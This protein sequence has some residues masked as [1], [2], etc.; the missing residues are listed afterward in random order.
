MLATGFRGDAFPVFGKALAARLRETGGSCRRARARMS[1]V[2]VRID[3]RITEF[4]S[5]WRRDV[6]VP[7]PR[8]LRPRGFGL[9]QNL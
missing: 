8:F 5:G 7:V 2:A 1:P 4:V 6:E 3:E 9:T